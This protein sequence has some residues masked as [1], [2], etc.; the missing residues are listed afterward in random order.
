MSEPVSQ[1]I[2]VH[3]EK[4]VET[5]ILLTTIFGPLGLLYSTVTGALVMV[6]ISVVVVP[7]TLG[8]GLLLTWPVCILWGALAA[9]SAKTVVVAR[10]A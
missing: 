9:A 5:S 8:F 3:R 10:S 2:E 7:L 1:T 4:S 6:V